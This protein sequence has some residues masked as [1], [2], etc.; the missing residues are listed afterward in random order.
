VL[1]A[2]VGAGFREI[3][4][5]F[6]SG[7]QRVLRKYATNKWD[8]RYNIKGLIEMCKDYGLT[9]AGNYM[10]GYPDE[11][12]QEIERTIDMAKEHMAAGLDSSNFFL[13]MPLPGTPLFESAMAEGYLPS[14]WDPDR[15]NWTKAN[16][17]N[18]EVPPQELEELRDRA[19]KEINNQDYVA[20]KSDMAVN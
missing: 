4:L 19:W 13:V 18:T 17:V 16:M 6:E 5:P 8:T 12:R 20:Y 10:L 15:M 3:V 14:D 11:T 1:E 9:I 7:T 2:L